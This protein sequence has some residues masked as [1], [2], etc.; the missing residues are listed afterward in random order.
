ML[1][2]YSNLVCGPDVE[3]NVVAI[4]RWRHV[5]PVVVDVHRVEHPG[6]GAASAGQLGSFTSQI[7]NKREPQRVA[8][9][10]FD[11]RPVQASSIDRSLTVFLSVRGGGIVDLIDTS[12]ATMCKVTRFA[13]ARNVA[14]GLHPQSATASA[15]KFVVKLTL[16]LKSRRR[17]EGLSRRS[18][19]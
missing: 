2:S 8:W 5:Q 18:C 1:T 19:A 14:L 4:S 13:V 15:R 12:F 10:G 11:D 7:I 6:P 17:K 9:L 3:Q 16:F